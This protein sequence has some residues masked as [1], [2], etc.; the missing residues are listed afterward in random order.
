MRVAARSRAA[1]RARHRR[2]RGRARP[3]RDKNVNLPT[4]VLYGK[5][6]TLTVQ[7][8]GQLENADQFRRLIVAYR[9]GAPVHLGE[10]GDV[11]RRRRRTTRRRAGTTASARSCSPSSASRARTP[12]TSRD[13]VKEALAELEQAIAADA[14]R[15]TSATTARWRFR[16]VGARREV[17]ARADARAR[18]AG[19]LPVPA[20]PLGDDHPEPR[21]ADVDHRH[22]LGDVRAGLQ[23][24]QPVAD[25]ADA[26]GRASSSTTRS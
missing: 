8:T 11:L 7:A 17:H 19:D 15:F 12:W 9:N 5:D 14:S 21:A 25:G 2:R 13:A 4:G 18:R 6:T 20:Q 26:R 10:L 3:I 24:R 16:S 23:P 1:R 22:V